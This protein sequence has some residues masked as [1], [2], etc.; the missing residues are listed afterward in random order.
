MEEFFN[1]EGESLDLTRPVVKIKVIGVG[2]G[3]NNAIN[4]M[5]NAKFKNIELVSVNTDRSVLEANKAQ[6]RVAIGVQLTKG[7][8]AGNDPAIGEQAAEESKLTIQ[9]ILK[10]TDLVFVTAGMGG[11]TGTGAAPV[12]AR[13]AREAGILT[14]GVVTKPFAFEGE[15][16]MANAE[17]GIENLRKYVDIIMIIPNE[18]LLEILPE[19]STIVQNFMYA[20]EVLRQGIQGISDTILRTDYI[21]VDFADV[22][23]IIKSTE[24]TGIGKRA[25]MGIGRKKGDNKVFAALQEAVSSPLLETSIEGAQKLLITFRCGADLPL[26]EI[27]QAAKLVKDVASK[28]CEIIYG[29]GIDESLGES[30]EVTIIAT[31]LKD[32]EEEDLINQPYFESGFSVTPIEKLDIEGQKAD[33]TTRLFENIKKTEP[34]KPL[35]QQVRGAAQ[36]PVAPAGATQT[37]IKFD[38]DDVPPFLRKIRKDN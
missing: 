22:K 3:G 11:G 35:H 27:S 34:Q 17:K 29:Q 8:G 15:R 14:V 10:D 37:S 38:D 2:G 4:R 23:K 18:K 9:E 20:D 33:L 16:K 24:Q 36:Q 28:D 5:A 12:I 25:H 31:G 1:K 19:T 30:V 6:T 26:R 7:H 21:N 32:N 13:M